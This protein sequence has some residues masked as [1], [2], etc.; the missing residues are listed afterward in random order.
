MSEDH[1]FEKKTWRGIWC[2]FCQDDIEVEQEYYQRDPAGENLILC[3]E[4]RTPLT[5]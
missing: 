5:E 3:E 1:Q 2:E 4:C